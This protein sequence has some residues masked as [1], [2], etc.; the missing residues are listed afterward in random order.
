MEN[1][2][3]F[4]LLRIQGSKALCLEPPLDPDLVTRIAKFREVD[5]DLTGIRIEVAARYQIPDM[6]GVA[7]LGEL[8]VEGLDPEGEGIIDTNNGLARKE[9]SLIVTQELWLVNEGG[10]LCLLARRVLGYDETK[11]LPQDAQ[12]AGM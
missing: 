11:S 4:G 5:G 3:L 1:I 7:F 2:L 10:S 9:H 8:V 6:V 12:N